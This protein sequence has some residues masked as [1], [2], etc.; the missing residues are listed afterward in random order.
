M[1]IPESLNFYTRAL[2]NSIICGDYDSACL[3]VHYI[4]NLYQ[5]FDLN[6][7]IYDLCLKWFSS[8]PETSEPYSMLNLLFSDK[9]LHVEAFD[10][11]TLM[12]LNITCE[13]VNNFKTWLSAHGDAM[14]GFITYRKY[15]M[16]NACLYFR[17]VDYGIAP[18][19]AK[20]KFDSVPIIDNIINYISEFRVR[21]GRSLPIYG[22][23]YMEALDTLGLIQSCKHRPIAYPALHE[24]VT[25]SLL[26]GNTCISVAETTIIT[27]LLKQWTALKQQILMNG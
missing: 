27:N 2:E 6:T 23:N 3:C 26:R 8:I 11:V 7:F 24:L 17:N 20:P 15:L 12:E 18:S 21:L 19:S 1:H 14:G 5:E 16:I 4:N 25:T 10:I 13:V 22:I 9:Y